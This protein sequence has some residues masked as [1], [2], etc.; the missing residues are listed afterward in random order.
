MTLIVRIEHV[1]AELLCVSMARVWFR[2]RNLDFAA[3][4]RDGM[5]VEDL[6]AMDDWFAKRVAARARREAEDGQ[7]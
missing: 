5:P 6:E 7:L 1:R 4:L 3:F 2:D